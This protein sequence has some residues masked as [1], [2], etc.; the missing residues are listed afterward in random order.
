MEIKLSE[1]TRTRLDLLARIHNIT[2]EDVI[3]HFLDAGI[4]MNERRDSRFLPNPRER[5]KQIV[6]ELSG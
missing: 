3:T 4:H 1:S 2:V 5:T 6:E